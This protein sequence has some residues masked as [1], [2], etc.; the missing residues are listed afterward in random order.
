[1]TVIRGRLD[2]RGHPWIYV[3]NDRTRKHV[4][5]VKLPDLSCV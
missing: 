4:G 1:V 5:W 2:Q 3:S